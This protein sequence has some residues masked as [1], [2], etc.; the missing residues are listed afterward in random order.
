MPSTSPTRPF[1]RTGRVIL[2]ALAFIT[3]ASLTACATLQELAAL[4]DVDFSLEGTRDGSLAGI[5]IESVRSYEDLGVM[6]VARLAEALSSGELPFETT[7]LVR[8][9]NPADNVQARLVQLDWTLFL[10]DRE[11]VSGVL[12]GEYVLPP[13]EPVSVPVGV[14]LDLLD[15]FDRQLEQAVQLALAAAGAGEPQRVRLEATPTVQTRLGPIPYP[16]PIRIEHEVG[17]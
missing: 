17:G 12:D 5:S 4:R 2:L 7:L 16:E 6:E 14:S 1:S 9:A 10:D 3:S 11:T 13:G 15:F 8:A